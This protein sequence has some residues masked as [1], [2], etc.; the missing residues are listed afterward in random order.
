MD[1]LVR[2]GPQQVNKECYTHA[3]SVNGND[4][5][6]E[7]AI[8]NVK[9]RIQ[10]AWRTNTTQVKQLNDSIS[11]LEQK[12]TQSKCDYQ[13][14]TGPSSGSR[15]ETTSRTNILIL[16]SMRTGSSFAGEMFNQNTDTLYVFEPLQDL[17]LHDSDPF[18]PTQAA[19]QLGDFYR[20]NFTSPFLRAVIND[21]NEREPVR[22]IDL[23]KSWVNDQL[24]TN[25]N[26]K[27]GT[28]ETCRKVT[29]EMAT[30][31]CN[32]IKIRAAKT[33]RL[34]HL[35]IVL[36]L[37]EDKG[38]NLKV[39]NILRDP[40]GMMSSVIPIHN[41]DYLVISKSRANKV[42]TAEH[43]VDKPPLRKRLETYCTSMLQ[44]VL[45]GKQL[46]LWI[47]GENYMPVRY[48]DLARNPHDVASQMY[49]FTGLGE[50]PQNIVKWLDDNTK[51]DDSQNNENYVYSTKRNSKLISENWRTKMTL[52]LVKAI[53]ETGSCT[54]FMEIMN[55]RIVETTTQLLNLSQSLVLP[56][57]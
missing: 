5:Q 10:E 8:L 28:F 54:K 44:N 36:H 13:H 56:L 38:I 3:G 46:S 47:G 29:P 50:L 23:V 27:Q 49:R 43:Y 48:E 9:E 40:R 42:L 45:L 12:I 6:I 19:Q 7:S 33:V 41:N 14:L 1:V 20:C 34:P 24:C 2:N 25:W 15:K 32:K 11:L 35:N 57:N 26:S 18:L 52:G 31:S 16:A 17:G 4:Q 55:Y 22:K 39:I 53:Q 51:A 30:E 21:F 37:M